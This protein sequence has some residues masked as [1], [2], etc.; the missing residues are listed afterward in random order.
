[1]HRRFF[2][3]FAA[4]LLAAAAPAL[5]GSFALNGS[6]WDTSDLDDTFGGQIALGIPL[7]QSMV[8]LD[9]RAGYYEELTDEPFEALLEEP[10]PVFEEESMRVIP[11]ELGLRF[12][13]AREEPINLYLGAGA[14]YFFFDPERDDL[15]VDDELGYYLLGGLRLG[16]AEG[17]AFNVEGYYC[18]VEAVFVRGDIGEPEEPRRRDVDV[19]GPGLNLGIVWT[20][21]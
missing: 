3:V 21:D 7:R 17:A 20:W 2:A 5:A 8:D 4:A 11:A 1:M 9:V 13:F 14:S 6:Y 18:A 12:N 16:D 15:D 10:D 19:A